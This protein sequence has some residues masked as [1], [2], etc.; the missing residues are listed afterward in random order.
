MERTIMHSR[1]RTA[2]LIAALA[3]TGTFRSNVARADLTEAKTLRGIDRIT[4][5][6]KLFPPPEFRET[7]VTER[8]LRPLIESELQKNGIKVVDG[9]DTDAPELFVNLNALTRTQ[10]HSY[11]L[12]MALRQGVTLARDST[13]KADAAKTWEQSLFGIVPSQDFADRIQHDTMV[14]VWTF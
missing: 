5:V 13:V 8:V 7:G 12:S 9:S 3:L 10:S 1:R 14:L 4:V 6:I 11:G 2:V